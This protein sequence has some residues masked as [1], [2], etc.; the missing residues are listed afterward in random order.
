[1]PPVD[2]IRVEEMINY[3]DYQYPQPVGIHPFS[4]TTET[5]DSPWKE[6][7]KLI[8]IGIQAKDLSVKQLPAANLVF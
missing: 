3:F 5:V 7:A 4:V 2:A 6:N 8:K 1:L